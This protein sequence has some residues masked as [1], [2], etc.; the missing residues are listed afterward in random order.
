MGSA[1]GTPKLVRDAFEE[2]CAAA[3]FTSL[4]CGQVEVGVD[5]ALAAKYVDVN[6]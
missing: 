4:V 3:A 5:R 6:I 1:S 2:V